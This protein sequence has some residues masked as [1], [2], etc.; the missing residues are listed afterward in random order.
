M[1]AETGGA[2]SWH[3]GRSGSP[4]T[5]LMGTLCTRDA[6]RPVAEK[7]SSF[8]MARGPLEPRDR[9]WLPLRSRPR[10]YAPIMPA[11]SA[12][13]LPPNWAVPRGNENPREDRSRPGIRAGP[14][15]LSG[16]E[17]LKSWQLS[18]VAYCMELLNLPHPARRRAI[19]SPSLLVKPLS[20]G[21]PKGN[22]VS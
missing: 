1:K 12:E 21:L 19:A 9:S 11:Q 7:R 13:Q 2:Q 3:H 18:Q 22:D 16:I 4:S 17:T 20:R 6:A 8:D 5:G 14:N 15:G 10:S